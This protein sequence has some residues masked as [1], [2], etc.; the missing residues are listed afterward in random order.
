MR[1]ESRHRHRS[2]RIPRILLPGYYPL[3]DVGSREFRGADRW[4]SPSAW[5]RTAHRTLPW[6]ARR[7]LTLTDLGVLYG[8]RDRLLGVAEVAE[9]LGVSTATVHKLCESGELRYIRIVAS[10]RVHPV[11]LADFMEERLAPVRS[12]PRKR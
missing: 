1:L 9:Q 5:A 10:I 4:S 3:P 7:P 12:G 6:P 11:D 8:G 2:Q